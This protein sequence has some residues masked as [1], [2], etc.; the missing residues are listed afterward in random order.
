MF[1]RHVFRF[2]FDI[3][4]RRM[5]LV[6]SPASAVLTAQPHRNAFLQQ[7]TKSQRLRHPVIDSPF[8]LRHLGALLQ[9]FL[10][11]RVNVKIAGIPHQ[12]LADFRQLL[13]PYAGF[14]FVR[15]FVP[16]AAIRIPVRRHLPHRRRLFQFQRLFLRRIHFFAHLRH[17][18]FGIHSDL[19]GINLPQRRAVLNLPVTQRLR[20]RRIVHFAVPVFPVTN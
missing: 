14:H 17:N 8:A 10:H 16:P 13:F 20:D 15:R 12:R 18:G 1:Q 3:D 6:E 7:R 11:F 19:L 4:Q 9:K 5:P 2:V